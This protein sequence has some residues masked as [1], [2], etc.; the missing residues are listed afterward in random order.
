MTRKTSDACMRIS[1]MPDDHVLHTPKEFLAGVDYRTNRELER[2]FNK[3][4]KW[5]VTLKIFVKAKQLFYGMQLSDSFVVR[6]ET[7]KCPYQHIPFAIGERMDKILEEQLADVFK[8]TGH[9][10]ADWGLSDET[11]THAIVRAILH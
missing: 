1:L 6:I 10:L 3:P 2:L 7:S 9:T 4:R 8:E 5:A 11:E